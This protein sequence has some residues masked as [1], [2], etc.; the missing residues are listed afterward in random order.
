MSVAQKDGRNFDSLKEKYTDNTPTVNPFPV[1]MF[2]P[3]F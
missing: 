3:T 1:L 2:N